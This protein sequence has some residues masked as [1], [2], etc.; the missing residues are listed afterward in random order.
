MQ[1]DVLYNRFISL[2][3]NLKNELLDYMEFLIFKQ[4]PLEVKNH[5]K[6]GCMKGMFVMMDDFDEP[7]DEFKEY[8]Q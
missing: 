3:H 6:A 5:P 7:L 8:M 2:P 1:D 4:K